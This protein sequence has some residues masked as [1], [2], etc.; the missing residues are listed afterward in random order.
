MMRRRG[1]IVGLALILALVPA[2]YR[3][4]GQANVGTRDF[5]IS[6]LDGNVQL[7]PIYSFTSSEAQIYSGLYEGL[8]SY[9]P[10]PWSRCPL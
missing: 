2:V 10:S 1:T 8:V 5:V 4:N 6:F 7:N 9:H 3:V